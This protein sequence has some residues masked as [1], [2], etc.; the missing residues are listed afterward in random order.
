MCVFTIANGAQLRIDRTV[1]SLTVWC[2][3]ECFTG[4]YLVGPVPY[5]IVLGLDWLTRH[6]V[7]WYFQSD[8]LRTYLDGKWCEL[9]LMSTHMDKRTEDD[10]QVTPKRTSPNR[11]TTF[12]LGRWLR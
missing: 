12:W 10:N 5:D 3:R 9:P 1:K 2:G 4:D 7:S 8:K 6:K 11:H